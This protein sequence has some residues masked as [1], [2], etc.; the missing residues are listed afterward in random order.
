M[1][2][3]PRVFDFMGLDSEDSVFHV[4]VSYMFIISHLNPDNS[5]FFPRNQPM[6]STLKN[7]SPGSKGCCFLNRPG[8]VTVVFLRLFWVVHHFSWENPLFLWPF[9]IAMLVH[10]RVFWR[11]W[12][13]IDSRFVLFPTKN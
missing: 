9:S 11:F 5:P 1:F 7:P 13:V 2:F 12:P 8:P 4:H 10:Q 3:I 6:A